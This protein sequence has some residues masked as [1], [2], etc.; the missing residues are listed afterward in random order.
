MYW[1][2]RGAFEPTRLL[3]SSNED[4]WSQ[5]THNLAKFLTGFEQNFL[6]HFISRHDSL[7]TIIYNVIF[8][9]RLSC[10]NSTHILHR[11]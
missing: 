7:I 2:C 8:T 10:L 4:L 3:L 6:L 9:R 1:T 5:L 11:D